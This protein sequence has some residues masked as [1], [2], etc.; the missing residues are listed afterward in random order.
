ML[1]GSILSTLDVIRSVCRTTSSK[2]PSILTTSTKSDA[3]INYY[4]KNSLRRTNMETC[5]INLSQSDYYNKW[6]KN[7]TIQLRI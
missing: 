3:K 7:K 4:E 5:W 6:I 1:K 2:N